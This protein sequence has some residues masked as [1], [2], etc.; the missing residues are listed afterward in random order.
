[1]RIAAAEMFVRKLP[2]RCRPLLPADV[3]GEDSAG[4]ASGFSKLRLTM[5]GDHDPPASS[6]DAGMDDVDLASR[7]MNAKSESGHGLV[8]Q[9]CVL[10][11]GPTL[12]GKARG[13]TVGMIGPY[14]VL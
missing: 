12:M 2:Q 5:P 11:A 4:G 13:E 14:L 9:D 10:C 7:R 8:E 1:M 3:L 6:L